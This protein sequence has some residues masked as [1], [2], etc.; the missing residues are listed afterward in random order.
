MLRLKTGRS[1]TVEVPPWPAKDKIA[2]RVC[3]V[4][5]R[6]RSKIRR[7]RIQMGLS[8]LYRVG[9]IIKGA[10]TEGVTI[11][12]RANTLYLL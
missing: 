7:A 12:R 11:I 8:Q 3:I 1:I 9:L 5:D 6:A 2:I 4:D 10:Y